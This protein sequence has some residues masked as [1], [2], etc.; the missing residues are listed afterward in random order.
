M[1]SEGGPQTVGRTGRPPR[2]RARA[3]VLGGGGRRARAGAAA[4]KS[5]RH[6]LA[7]ESRRRVPGGVP[8]GAARDQAILHRLG[9]TAARPSKAVRVLRF[10]LPSPL[11]AWWPA[12][13]G[14]IRAGAA[15]RAQRYERLRPCR[16]PVLLTPTPRGDNGSC[17]FRG[18]TGRVAVEFMTGPLRSQV[19]GGPLTAWYGKVVDCMQ[20]KALYLF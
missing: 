7:P 6:W 18:P 4:G 8:G 2:A 15:A 9:Q 1:T 20:Y 17:L 10:L 14:A 3:R 11:P 16:P 13:E 5:N 12:S 19:F